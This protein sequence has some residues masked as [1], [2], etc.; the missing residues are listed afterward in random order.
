MFESSGSFKTAADAV[1]RSLHVFIILRIIKKVAIASRESILL[2][3]NQIS[4]S[5]K[6]FL[7]CKIY[8]VFSFKNL[9]GFMHG[10]QTDKASQISLI[11]SSPIIRQNLINFCTNKFN[12]NR[13]I[14]STSFSA[15]VPV[16]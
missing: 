2:P 7:I 1:T 8:G 15:G 4:P 6:Q 13:R 14:I 10:Q 5:I 9:F 11:F 16:F 3:K 12:L